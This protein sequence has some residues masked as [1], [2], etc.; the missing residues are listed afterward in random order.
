ME[1]VNEHG[2]GRY[3]VEE[4]VKPVNTPGDGKNPVTEYRIDGHTVRLSKIATLGWLIRFYEDGSEVPSFR[5]EYFD[6]R[7]KALEKAEKVV[8]TVVKQ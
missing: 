8:E 4:F 5:S 6:D 3:T 2:T 1:K 7:E